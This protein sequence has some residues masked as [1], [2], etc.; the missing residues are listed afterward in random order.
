MYICI[1]IC[2][3][4]SLV[5]HYSSKW[6]LH[7]SSN[8]NIETTID[9]ETNKKKLR[10]KPTYMLSL[11]C[12]LKEQNAMITNLQKT[13]EHGL[14]SLNW[15]SQ[16]L[17]LW[18]TF[19]ALQTKNLTF[20]YFCSPYNLQRQCMDW[21]YRTFHATLQPHN[22][23]VDYVR[24]LFKPLKDSPH[25]PVCN[26]RIFFKFWVMGFCGWRCKWGRFRPFFCWRYWTL[27]PNCTREVFC[28][29]VNWKL[30]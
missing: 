9:D 14:Y 17:C 4:V 12:M 18:W 28:S 6:Q 7:A 10:I 1:Y 5:L 22:S 23:P 25:L 19:L 26:E 13:S 11:Q 16:C 29:S 21:I 30:G 8:V 24:E 20:L 15:F 3:C 27:G 2:V